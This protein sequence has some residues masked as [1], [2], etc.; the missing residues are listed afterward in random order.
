MPG[1]R[2]HLVLFYFRH[3]YFI[4]KFPN[5]LKCQMQNWT[6]INLNMRMTLAIFQTLTKEWSRSWLAVH[7]IFGSL[8]RQWERKS[9]PSGL[10]LSGIGGLCPIPTLYI[11]WKLCSYSCQGLY[12]D[13]KNKHKRMPNSFRVQQTLTLELK[14]KYA[15]L[16][17]RIFFIATTYFSQ[18]STKAAKDNTHTHTHM[19]RCSCVPM[20]LCYKLVA[21]MVCYPI[22]DVLPSSII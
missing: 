7:L 20:K 15:R 1:K 11:I 12:K 16:T 4:F 17:G 14:R 18:G 6:Q 9:F 5:V 13:R 3:G 2:R 22:W 21:R 8:S 10:N 19:H